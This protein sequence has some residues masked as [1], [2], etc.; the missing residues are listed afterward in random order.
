M[1]SPKVQK[2]SHWLSK[3]NSHHRDGMIFFWRH[4]IS[5]ISGDP[6]DFEGFNLENL[7][8]KEQE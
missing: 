8:I 5:E 6:S 3:H 1:E 2:V 4:D 7:K